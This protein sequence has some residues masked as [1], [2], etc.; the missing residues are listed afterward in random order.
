MFTLPIPRFDPGTE[1]H[2]DLAAAAIEA[3]R[4]A[5]ALEL[6]A[7]V[8]FRRARKLIRDALSESGVAQHIDELVARL[9][10]ASSASADHSRS[11]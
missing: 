5:A 10:D 6:A 3:E 11:E 7:T 1:L 4:L 2:N 9:L 8:K